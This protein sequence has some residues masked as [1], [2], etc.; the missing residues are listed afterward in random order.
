M[1]RTNILIYPLAIIKFILPYLLQS[2]IYEPHRDEFLYLAEGHHLAWGYLEI[3]PVLSFFAWLTHL[4]GDGMFWVKFW[5]DL[6][7]TL[8]FII[9]AKAVQ[10]I[11]GGAIATFLVFLPFIFGAYLR[12][13]FLFQPNT[14]EVFFWT[15]IA[16]SV[17]RYIQTQKSKFLYVLG[18]SIGLGMLSKYSVAFF[19]V[20]ILAGLL[21]TR[22]RSV[23]SNEHLYYAAGI[24][25]LIFLPTLLWEY[26]HH[27]PVMVH[28]KELSRTQ[29]QYVSP[30]SFLADQLLMNLPCVFIWL[31]GLYFVAFSF[32]GRKYRAFAWAYVFVII[33]LLVLHGKSYYSLGM[34]PILFAFGAY[35]LEKF[36][37]NRSRAWRYRFFLIPILLGSLI[38]PLVLPISKPEKLAHY[39]QVMHFEKSGTLRW[40]DLQNHPLPQDFADMLG[41]E[42][43]AQKAAAAYD[44]LNDTDKAHT[45]LFCDN[46]GEAGA[47]N[48]YRYKYDLPEA[49]S[50]NGT[51]LYWM[52]KNIHIDNLL[53]VTDDTAEMQ[54]PF[55]KNFASATV[56]G[57]VTNKYA[58]EK[59]SLIILFKGAN[60]AFNKMFREKIND[61][62]KVYGTKY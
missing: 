24:A 21:L 61:D 49:H 51:F 46:Y 30:V 17:L 22:Q 9:A 37:G 1:K 10:K 13:F 25:L 29:L 54:H 2:S 57:S 55:V 12:L 39:Y 11:G 31:A 14:P 32:E 60:D 42:E 52:P 34:Y 36:S 15:L 18:I 5:P 56:V 3:P 45:F 41:W 33:L 62:M 44:S 43:M 26:H 6:F 8:T 50:D 23:F 16:Y 35:H 48:Y 28:M 40:E 20:S 38:L 59:G 27:F 19:V 7:G 58:R 4:L 53:L 47:L